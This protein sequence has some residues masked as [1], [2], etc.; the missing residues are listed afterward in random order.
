MRNAQKVHDHNTGRKCDN[1]KCKG[2]LYD[3]II[4]FGENLPE[5]DLDDGF[6]HSQLSDLHIVLGSSLRVTPAAEMPATTAKLGKNLVIVNLQKTPLDSVATL[7]INAMCDNVMEMV[8]K[9]LG[10]DIP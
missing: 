1:P 5:K 9:K 6:A 3:T 8:M 4:N 2:N 7:R 10:L